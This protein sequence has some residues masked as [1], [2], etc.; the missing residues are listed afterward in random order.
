MN[1]FL[2]APVPIQKDNLQTVIDAGWI[3][4]A[5]VC[6]GVTARLPSPLAPDAG[7]S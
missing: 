2:L 3:D 4:Q 6:A 1:S 7:P 5:T